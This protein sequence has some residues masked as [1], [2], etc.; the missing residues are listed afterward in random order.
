VVIASNSET[1]LKR[2]SVDQRNNKMVKME[3]GLQKWSILDV[4][5]QSIAGEK[6]KYVK[7]VWKKS[8]RCLKASLNLKVIKAWKSWK[9]DTIARFYNKKIFPQMHL[10]HFVQYLKKGVARKYLRVCTLVITVCD[11]SKYSHSASNYR[12]HRLTRSSI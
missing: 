6:K 9:F 1:V 10:A 3:V 5:Y 8:V 4:S 7:I 11:G 12:P 2:Q